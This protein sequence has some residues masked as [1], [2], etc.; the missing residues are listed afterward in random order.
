MSSNIQPLLQ[1]KGPAAACQWQH[2]HN[3]NMRKIHH[4]QKQPC[5]NHI[6]IFLHLVT[7]K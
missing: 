7:L 6:F 3:A 1:L 2:V 5:K 4:S